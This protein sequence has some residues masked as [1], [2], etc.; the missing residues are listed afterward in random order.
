MVVA[1][2]HDVVDSLLPPGSVPAQDRLQNLGVSPIVNVHLVYD[3]PVTELSIFAAVRSD[4]QYVFDRTEAAGL[5]NGRQCLALSLSAAESYI[6]W[7]ATDL[8]THFSAEL[9][10]L[11]PA[12]AHAT[13]TESIVTRETTATFNGVPGTDHLR[14]GAECRLPGVYLAGAWCDTG[15]PATME[16]AVRSGSKAG[17]LAARF[18][19]D[20]PPASPEAH[21]SEAVV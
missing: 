7:S 8:I 9:A 3:R 12:A 6:S 20:A 2:P 15:W 18:A 21:R 4:V 11:L 1:V 5:D 14:A 17:R 13:L 10:R 16:G 19:A